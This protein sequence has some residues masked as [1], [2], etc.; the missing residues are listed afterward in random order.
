MSIFDKLK[1]SDND[2]VN[3][4]DTENKN[5]V[6]LDSFKKITLRVIG[7]RCNMEYEILNKPPKSILSLYQISYRDGSNNRVIEKSAETDTEIMLELLNLCKV[8]SWNGFRG[9][10]PK[11]VND[12]VM[13]KFQAEVNEGQTMYAEGSEN[14]PQGY[15]EFVSTL[16]L[17]LENDRLHSS[18]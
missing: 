2:V 16:N 4:I 12:G 5:L 1:K 11:D 8:I 13:F 15:H 14:F 18:I 6:T 10:H 3:P 9:D 17:I 7:M